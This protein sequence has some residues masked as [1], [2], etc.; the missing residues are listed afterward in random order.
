MSF[1]GW[2]RGVD[3]QG[4]RTR[5]WVSHSA[6]CVCVLLTSFML[7]RGGWEKRPHPHAPQAKG[8][9]EK[10][11]GSRLIFCFH[12]WFGPEWQGLPKYRISRTRSRM[13]MFSNW[14][15]MLFQGVEWELFA[16]VLKFSR[17]VPWCT[18]KTRWQINFHYYFPSLLWQCAKALT[19]QIHFRELSTHPTTP[20]SK[21][22]PPCIIYEM[23]DSCVWRVPCGF[24][25]FS[26]SVI[27]RFLFYPSTLKL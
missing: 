10:L 22:T 12:G 25:K 5:G 13:K 27:S 24:V 15:M 19:I 26:L 21:S 1:R 9:R 4:G 14:E 2:L 20:M 8:A 11:S 17:K 3:F 23:W 16:K 18:A 7:W 6:Q